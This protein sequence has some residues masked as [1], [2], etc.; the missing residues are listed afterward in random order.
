LPWTIQDNLPVPGGSTN[1]DGLAGFINLP[2]E[3][4]RV[5][6]EVNGIRFGGTTIRIEALRMTTGELRP[7]YN[8]AR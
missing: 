8:Q 7:F 2:I 5:E 6:G 4:V 3:N 1:V